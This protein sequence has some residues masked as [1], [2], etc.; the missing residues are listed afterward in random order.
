[1]SNIIPTSAVQHYGERA[2]A[3]ENRVRELEAERDELRAKLDAIIEGNNPKEGDFG[4]SD[5]R[6]SPHWLG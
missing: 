2:V 3:A 5:P 1:M 4:Y 6:D